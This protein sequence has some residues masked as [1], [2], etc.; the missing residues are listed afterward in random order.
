MCNTRFK[1]LLAKLGFE[2]RR[3]VQQ[4]YEKRW[5]GIVGL[6]LLT[7]LL[8]GVASSLSAASLPSLTKELRWQVNIKRA[9]DASVSLNW[10]LLSEFYVERDYQPVW[11][12]NSGLASRGD[13][14]LNLLRSADQDGF[15]RHTVPLYTSITHRIAVIPATLVRWA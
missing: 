10:R 14:W 15:L 12:D 4:K 3:C 6:A 13:I 11:L 7:F 5:Y 2:P 8:G 9:M 1:L